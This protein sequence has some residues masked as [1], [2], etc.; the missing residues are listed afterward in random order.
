MLKVIANT[1]S[2]VCSRQAPIEAGAEHGD[3]D[4]AECR[5]KHIHAKHIHAKHHRDGHLKR[6]PDKRPRAPCSF[7]LW[8]CV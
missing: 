7:G 3:V 4:R 6:A 1:A 8:D 5:A 2:S